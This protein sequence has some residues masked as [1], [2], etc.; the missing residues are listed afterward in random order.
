MWL[1]Q[2]PHYRSPENTCGWRV[3]NMPPARS[4]S[5]HI[6]CCERNGT[7]AHSL[8]FAA[9]SCSK[10]SKS[11]PYKDDVKGSVSNIQRRVARSYTLGMTVCVSR[12][13]LQVV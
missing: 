5:R 10:T 7:A 3:E 6:V 4:V 1:K 9:V 8:Q 11:D 2:I 13:D 12:T